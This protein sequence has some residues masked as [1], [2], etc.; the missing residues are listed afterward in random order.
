MYEA[1]LAAHRLDVYPERYRG[2]G[3]VYSTRRCSVQQ[4]VLPN[5]EK[6]LPEVVHGPSDTHPVFAVDEATVPLNHKYRRL[7]LRRSLD[8]WI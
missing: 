6:W 8:D 1:Q 5:P 3:I 2:I 7:W 4:E